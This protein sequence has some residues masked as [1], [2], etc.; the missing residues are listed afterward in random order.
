MFD[1]FIWSDFHS[2]FN[3][4]SAVRVVIVSDA[5]GSQCFAPAVEGDVIWSPN[6]FH[7]RMTLVDVTV[8]F[9]IILRR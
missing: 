1:L 4:E 8:A 9:L 6:A 2:R 7:R 5:V 3:S